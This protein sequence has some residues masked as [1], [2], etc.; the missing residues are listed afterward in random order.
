MRDKGRCRALYWSMKA[1]AWASAAGLGAGRARSSPLLRRRMHRHM[2]RHREVSGASNHCWP[3][4]QRWQHR[5]R[6]MGLTVC[7]PHHCY[8]HLQRQQQQQWRLALHG[9]QAFPS[10][11]IGQCPSSPLAC[12]A[13]MHNNTCTLT[14]KTEPGQ[15]LRTCVH[16]STSCWSQ[17]TSP[18]THASH[19]HGE[20]K[21]GIVGLTWRTGDWWW[22]LQ[23]PGRCDSWVAPGNIS[24]HTHRHAHR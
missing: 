13:R 23:N 17:Q 1:A 6:R 18:F 24:T 3:R 20:P 22:T 21:A 9:L 11:P 10:T 15:Q 4:S 5:S 19:R 7:C 2:H 12:K 16:V 8:C 14:T